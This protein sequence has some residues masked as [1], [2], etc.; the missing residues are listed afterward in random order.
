[1]TTQRDLKAT[2][3]RLRRTPPQEGNKDAIQRAMES[4]EATGH[5][6]FDQFHGITKLIVPGKGGRRGVNDEATQ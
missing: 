1:M 4:C 3:P 5:A 6:V 2:T